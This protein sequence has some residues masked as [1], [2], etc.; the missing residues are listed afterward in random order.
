MYTT[1]PPEFEPGA[2]VRRLCSSHNPLSVLPSI[3]QVYNKRVCNMGRA[4]AE[5][6]SKTGQFK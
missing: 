1:W 6:V 4:K 3:L 2:D 5:A